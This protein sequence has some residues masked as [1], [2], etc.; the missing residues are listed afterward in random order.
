MHLFDADARLP[1]RARHRRRAHPAR[2][3]HGLRHQVPRQRPGRGLLLRRGGGEQRR[4]PRGAQHGRAL[5]AAGHLHLREQPLRH[6]HGARAGA[7]RSTTSPSAPCSYDMASEV[8][9]GQDV[10]VDARRDGARGRARPDRQAPTLLEVRTYRFMGHSMSD[11]IHGH[12]RTKEE[13][14]EQRKRDPIAV[15]VAAPHRRGPHRRGRRQGD[16]TRTVIQEVEDAYQF[17]DEAPE[18]EPRSCTGRVCGRKA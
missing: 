3:R 14:E 16:W 6:G 10:L 9:D 17:A 8:V 15:L 13:V 1:R 2:H 18:P 4:V 11:P 5:E 7:A 12:Y